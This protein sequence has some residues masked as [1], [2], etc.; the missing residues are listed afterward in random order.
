ML[1]VADATVLRAK[2]SGLIEEES[3]AEVRGRSSVARHIFSCGGRTA[4]L[5]TCVL[6]GTTFLKHDDDDDDDGLAEDEGLVLE[7]TGRLLLVWI[8]CVA[9]PLVLSASLVRLTLSLA[10]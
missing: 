6:R 7:P 2:L 1:R 10:L 4:G 5:G 8:D 3:R 9:P